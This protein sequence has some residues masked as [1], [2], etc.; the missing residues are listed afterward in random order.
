MKLKSAVLASAAAASLA[1]CATAPPPSARLS[2]GGRVRAYNRPYEVNGRW[3]TPTDQPNYDRTGVASWYGYES[4]SRTTAD[5]EVFDARLATAAHPTLPI[6]SWIE[7]TNLDNG[8]SARVRLNDRGPFAGGRILDLSRGAAVELGFLARGTARVRVRYL[9]PA[10]PLAGD[11]PVWA[12]RAEPS[13]FAAPPAVMV[14]RATPS[15]PMISPRAEVAADAASA[16]FEADGADAR[17]MAASP[18]AA[19]APQDRPQTRD[20]GLEGGFAVQAGAF[21]DHDRAERAAERLAAAGPASILPLQR[22]DGEVL[23]L[24]V[25]GAWTE[26]EPAAAAR[27]RIA[28]LGFTDA[29][30]VSP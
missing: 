21:L 17:T 26:A 25:V 5:G 11:A 4:R 23:Y 1:A 29:K 7:V 6:P 15:P 8:R 19:P 28:A 10:G 13:R 30:V 24:V 20:P 16:S 9:G 18:D 3:Y 14:A 12:R 22:S 27:S 2:T